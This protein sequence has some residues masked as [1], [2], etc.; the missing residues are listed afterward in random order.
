MDLL[1]QNDDVIVYKAQ[2][3][4]KDNMVN[5][6]FTYIVY[7]FKRLCDRLKG[8]IRAIGLT[9]HEQIISTNELFTDKWVRKLK[10]DWSIE[11]LRQFGFEPYEDTF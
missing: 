8:W 5:H 10:C 9:E 6:S 11:G 4:D 7:I 3:Y 2:L 1:G